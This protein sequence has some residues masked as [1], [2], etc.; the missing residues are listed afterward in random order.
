MA[1]LIAI[2]LE[3]R[4][5]H[6][7]GMEHTHILVHW[8]GIIIECIQN[9]TSLLGNVTRSECES[10]T[11]KHKYLFSCIVAQTQRTSGIYIKEKCERNI[12][13]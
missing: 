1:A 5:S 3:R 13:I 6:F 8:H 10:D 2:A 4:L 12:R 11:E 7:N 9:E